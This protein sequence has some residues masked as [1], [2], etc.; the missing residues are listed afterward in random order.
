MIKP[1]EEIAVA[2]LVRDGKYLAVRGK[3]DS[4]WKLPGG[5]IEAGELPIEALARE[6]LE[7]IG[8]KQSTTK[9]E[10]P[11]FS[12]RFKEIR[13]T[14]HP[15]LIQTDQEPRRTLDEDNLTLEWQP[16]ER[17]LDDDQAPSQQVIYRL[18]K[19]KINGSSK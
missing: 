14:F 8:I 17:M 9:G 10:L 2:V 12:L 3:K 7:E 13:F 4:Y 19:D 5:G 18:V 15:Y 11:Q 6:L 16:L 1:V